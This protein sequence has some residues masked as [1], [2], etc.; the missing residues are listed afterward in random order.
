MPCASLNPLFRSLRSDPFLPSI[1]EILVSL[2]A[3][4]SKNIMSLSFLCFFQFAMLVYSAVLPHQL[5]SAITGSSAD[6][7]SVHNRVRAFA[8]V[9]PSTIGVCTVVMAWMCYRLYEEL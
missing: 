5:A 9:I 7:P 6:T 1:F 2:D 8:I 4:Q 3:L